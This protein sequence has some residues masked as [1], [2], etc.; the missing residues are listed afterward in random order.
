MKNTVRCLLVA[1]LLA[2]AIPTTA[3]ADVIRDWN[4]NMLDAAL[5]PPATNPLVMTRVAAIVESAVFDAVN[6]IE[7]RYTPIHVE[8]AAPRGA[9]RRAAAVQAAYATLVILYPAQQSTLAAR[10]TDS[11][12]EIAATENSRSITRGI[13]WG[14]T[15]ADGILAWRGT[16]GFTPPPPPFVGSID[17]GK[18]RPTPPAFLPGA[19]P[20]FATM[21]PWAINSPSQFRPAGAGMAGWI[22]RV[23]WRRKQWLPG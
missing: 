20:Q 11:L 15:V 8:P 6:G 10:R 1:A 12:A 14:Q 19:G 17:V 9:S 16:D 7:R 21:T 23:V 4:Q 18:W 5:V 2:N 3:R 13:Q 22:L